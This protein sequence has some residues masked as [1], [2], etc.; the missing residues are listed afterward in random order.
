M[1]RP[2]PGVDPRSIL[3]MKDGKMRGYL[4]MDKIKLKNGIMWNSM[5]GAVT[6]FTADE[7][8]IKDSML[9]ILGLSNIKKDDTRQLSAHE[10][11]W[12]FRSTRGIIRTSFFISIKAI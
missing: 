7:L 8:N 1:L 3:F 5:N 2:S 12:R 9:D 6:R 10:N 11:Q 4:M